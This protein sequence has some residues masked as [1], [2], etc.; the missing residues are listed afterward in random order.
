MEPTSTV[1]TRVW[2]LWFSCN[3]HQAHHHA[4]TPRTHATPKNLR[5]D[6]LPVTLRFIIYYLITFL[7]AQPITFLPR[8]HAAGAH[9]PCVCVL[10]FVLHR[11]GTPHAACNRPTARS[12]LMHECFEDVDDVAN[13]D[14]KR[15][16]V[17]K[18]GNPPPLED[19]DGLRRPIF[20]PVVAS[21][22][23]SLP[24]PL[25]ADVR[26]SDDVI[27]FCKAVKHQQR[28]YPCRAH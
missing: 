5:Y 8:L 20:R 9:R 4:H 27:A 14:P 7:A 13:L 19:T 17:A 23:C 6:V 25:S 12:A 21:R 26:A 2:L 22:C 24:L 16:P 11:G 3:A 15:R 28:T 10:T 1:G 18:S